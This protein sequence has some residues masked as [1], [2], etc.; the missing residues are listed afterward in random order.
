M[1]PE[2]EE[3]IKN[4]PENGTTW[5]KTLDDEDGQPCLRT[6]ALN[7]TKS[8][9]TRLKEVVRE[10]LNGEIWIHGDLYWCGAAGYK[11]LWEQRKYYSY[12]LPR[13]LDD[14]WY[15]MDRRPGMS[16]VILYTHEYA[17]ELFK[18]YIPYFVLDDKMCLMEYAIRFRDYPS[19]EQLVKAGYPQLVWDK[20]VIKMNKAQKK[21]LIHWLM[22]D[23]NGEYVKEHRTLFTDIQKAMKRGLSIERYYYEQCI[24]AYEKS[25][26]ENNIRRSRAQC[27]EVYKYLNNK[28]NPQ[29]IGLQIYIDYLRIAKEEGF[30]MRAKSTLFP[31]DCARVHDNLAA[32]RKVKESREL[33]KK[34]KVIHSKLM[35]LQTKF[36]DLRVV[37][38]TCQKDFLEWGKKLQI[39][40]GTYGYDKK[41]ARGDCIILMVYVED[42]PLECCELIKKQGKL[43]IE[44]LRGSHNGVSQ[45]HEDCEKVINKFIYNYQTSQLGATA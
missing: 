25:F 35:P 44:Q 14:N 31:R 17:E 32:K 13:E 42:Q 11:V 45:R 4:H 6:Y 33:N 12:F 34:L 18:K 8:R 40:V 29:N 43:H 39:C 41:M 36:K 10:Y 7:T 30:N 27:E 28:K 2:I 23:G 26:K 37:V 5:L 1:R 38:P 21:R 15:Q 22:N 24:D 19:V 3:Y 16:S 20:R 9:G